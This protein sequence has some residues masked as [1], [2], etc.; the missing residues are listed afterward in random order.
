MTRQ[1][2]GPS[3]QISTEIN[4]WMALRL[5]RHV[6]AFCYKATLFKLKSEKWR[7]GKEIRAC[8][9]ALYLDP[10]FLELKQHCYILCLQDIAA[11]AT[12]AEM[13]KAAKS[14]LDSYR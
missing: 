13:S 9:S 5:F 14:H 1:V 6:D 12:E 11:N 2:G 10:F 7:G 4:R 8:T 3:E